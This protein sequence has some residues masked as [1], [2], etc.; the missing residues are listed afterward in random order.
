M[1]QE[2]IWKCKPE[3]IIETGVAWGGSIVF[4]ANLLSTLGRGKVI[5]IDKVLPKKI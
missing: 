4:H 1:T 5:G 2:I 3:V